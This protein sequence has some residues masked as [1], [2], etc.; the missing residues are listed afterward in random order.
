MLPKLN[1]VSALAALV[2]FFLPWVEV[3]CSG[4]KSA[5][6]T[7]FQTITGTA[8]PAKRSQ[9]HGPKLDSEGES[10][11]TSYLAAFALVGAV[12]AAVIGFASMIADRADLARATAFLCGCAFICLAI[13]LVLGFPAETTLRE[14]LR[15]EQRAE[16]KPKGPLDDIGREFA[17]KLATEIKVRPSKWF[18]LELGALGIPPLLMLG[19]SMGPRRSARD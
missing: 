7:G 12:S 18:Y 6:Q 9:A 4:E 1:L 11:G 15:G 19:A 8:T 10:L 13:Q 17:Q 2:F 3:E 14:K 5:T 16:G